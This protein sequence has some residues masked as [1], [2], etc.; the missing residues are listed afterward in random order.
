MWDPRIRLE[1]GDI[2]VGPREAHGYLGP[3]WSFG[4][5][6]R[7]G[8][9]DATFAQAVTVKAVVYA[10]LPPREVD[11]A[12]RASSAPGPAP[13]WVNV[14]VDG[15]HVAKLKVDGGGYRDL[16]LRIPPDQKRPPVSEITL[17]LEGDSD[18][19]PVFKLD[20]LIFK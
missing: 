4:Q 13:H 7:V 20:R 10:S 19:V 12:L 6:E 18:G 17:H 3:G 11:L 1:I 15:R 8:T 2:D 14:H 9:G 16:S 5:R